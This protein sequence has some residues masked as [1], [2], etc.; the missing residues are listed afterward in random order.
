[1][2]DVTVEAMPQS[3]RDIFDRAAAE[4]SDWIFLVCG[5]T[6]LAMALITPNWLACKEL[7]GQRD[8][9]ALQ[10][11]RFEEQRDRYE[12]FHAAL[13]A[14]DPVLLERLAF[15]QLGYKRKGSEALEPVSPEVY[16]FGGA[17]A[18]DVSPVSASVD[19]WLL[20]PMPRLGIDWEPPRIVSSR[21]TRLATAAPTRL[22]LIAAGMVC[23]AGGLWP[24][25][26]DGE[27]AG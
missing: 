16:G 19:P 8:L 11:Q 22:A 12:S 10:L 9:M 3:C 24:R 2:A 7:A 15:T 26:K 20:E 5:V 25:G 27:H 18:P 1:M 4:L 21:L 23:L 6:L 14:S 17:A 13:K